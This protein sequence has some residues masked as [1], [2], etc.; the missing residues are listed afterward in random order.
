MIHECWFT[1]ELQTLVDKLHQII[2]SMK[3]LE[4]KQSLVRSIVESVKALSIPE[5]DLI[6][7][8]WLFMNNVSS[9]L[10]VGSN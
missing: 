1:I 5:T 4:S 2:W 9:A 6:L 10:N 7:A 3:M 8:R